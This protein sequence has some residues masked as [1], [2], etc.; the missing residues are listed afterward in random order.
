MFATA[1][2]MAVA[3]CSAQPMYGACYVTPEVELTAPCGFSN[4]TSDC[5]S[6]T[7]SIS[8]NGTDATIGPIGADCTITAVL[9]NG[10]T[11]IIHVTVGVAHD[12]FCNGVTG[13]TSMDNGPDFTSPTCKA[14]A[15]KDASTD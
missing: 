13:V 4:V 8:G 11:Q 9:G 7:A 12:A 3:G 10:Q 2:A 15:L 14:P 1:S 6:A 5:A